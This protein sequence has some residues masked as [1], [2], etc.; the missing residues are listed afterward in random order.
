MQEDDQAL[1]DALAAGSSEAFESVY[2]IH[3]DRL[4][5]A[6]MFLLRGERAI[7]EDVLHDVFMQLI[8]QSSTLR[9]TGSLQNYLITCCL[10]RARDRLRRIAIDGRAIRRAVASTIKTVE[11]S[12]RVEDEE[13]RL[14]VMQSLATLPDEQREVVTLHLHGEMTF[15]QAADSLGITVNT[16]KSRYRY[17]LEKLR[18]W[19]AVDSVNTGDES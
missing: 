10:N 17:A 12:A 16:A 3:K 9:I 8:D 19:W 6:T 4:L 14:R 13:Q 2:R 5:T 11:P 18:E 1:V 7:A 15:Q